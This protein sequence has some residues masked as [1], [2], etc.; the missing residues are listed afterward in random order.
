MSN[1]TKEL[2]I[3][4][5]AIRKFAD[6]RGGLTK[7]YEELANSETSPLRSI[8]EAY[9]SHSKKHVIRGLHYQRGSASQEKIIYC[10]TGEF[11][12]VSVDLTSG[13]SFGK[14]HVE[15]LSANDDFV[16]RI[17][18]AFAHGIISLSDDTTYL[19]L[20]PDNYVPSAESGIHW[21]SLGLDIGIRDPI[22][23]DKDANWPS[24]EEVLKA[25]SV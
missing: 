12:D 6:D 15:H 9:I 1:E 4:K 19:N 13:P 14:V 16:L 23:S 25:L 8:R 24:L 17:P 10:V 5:I 18:G 2:S 21:S 11:L 3:Q 22:V 20:S 7:I